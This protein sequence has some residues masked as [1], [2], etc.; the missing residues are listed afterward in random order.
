MADIC[1]NHQDTR[2]LIKKQDDRL[3]DHEIRIDKLEGV[4][5]SLDARIKALCDRI[6]DLIALMKWAIGV[7]VTAIAGG[8][9]VIIWI[10]DK[11]VK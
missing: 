10:V 6:D 11:A 2:D 9:P 5:I 7:M 1:S 8:I 3:D 4:G